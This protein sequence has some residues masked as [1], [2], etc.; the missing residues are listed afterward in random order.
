MANMKYQ[1]IYCKATYDHAG[2]YSHNV[3]K[4]P[5]MAKRVKAGLVGVLAICLIGLTG[6]E[7]LKEL[8]PKSEYPAG[9]DRAELQLYK[10]G[11]VYK[12]ICAVNTETKALTDCVEV[13]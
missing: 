2:S 1:C 11:Q 13:Q 6:C 8:L 7:A 9:A 3:Y 10:G 4:C 12:Y 5:K